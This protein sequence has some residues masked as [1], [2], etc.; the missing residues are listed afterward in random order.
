M[1]RGPTATAH[2]QAAPP[3]P[4]SENI[5]T[6]TG[7]ELTSFGNVTIKGPG[8]GRLIL[9]GNNASR[10]FDINDTVSGT[11]SPATTDGNSASPLL[12]RSWPAGRTLAC[13]PAALV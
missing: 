1:R 2:T 12:T 4:H 11:D 10:V 8:A 13:S 5:I 7:G 3:L 6:L 9:D